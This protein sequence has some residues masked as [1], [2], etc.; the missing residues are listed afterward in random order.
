MR[1]RRFISPDTSLETDVAHFAAAV[2][3]ILDA[4]PQDEGALVAAYKLNT[5]CGFAW[6][7]FSGYAYRTKF[8]ALQEFIGRPV[9]EP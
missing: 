3:D 9:K 4:M 2:A 8:H 7:A 1:S 5:L 6:S